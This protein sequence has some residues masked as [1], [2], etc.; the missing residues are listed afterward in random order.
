MSARNLTYRPAAQSTAA[1]R[2]SPDGGWRAMS[3]ATHYSL[4]IVHYSLFTRFTP[5]AIT[6][7]AFSPRKFADNETTRVA[8]FAN[9]HIGTF[10]NYSLFTI[11]YSLGSS[12]DP[13]SG[14]YPSLSPYVYCA[15]N[16]VKCVDWNGE[17]VINGYLNSINSAKKIK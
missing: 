10:A 14:K 11:H 3:P 6:C 5:C 8:Q 16:P 7:L 1:A 2:P 15:N 13:M 4:F 9:L 17:E 12:V